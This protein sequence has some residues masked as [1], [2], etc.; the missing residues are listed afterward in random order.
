MT[1]QPNSQQQQQQQEAV[2]SELAGRLQSAK[3]AVCRFVREEFPMTERN[4]SSECEPVGQGDSVGESGHKFSI[5][6]NGKL[7]H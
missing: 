1:N 4:F 2:E 5:K 3:P 6:K 7:D